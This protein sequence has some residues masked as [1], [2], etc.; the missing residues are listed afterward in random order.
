MG[1][2]GDTV[3]VKRGGLV[4]DPETVANFDFDPGLTE[5]LAPFVEPLYKHYWRIDTE[6]L[7]HIPEE[8]GCLLVAN[9]GGILPFDAAMVKMAVYTKS[10][11]RHAW[12]LIER[13]VQTLPFLNV[14]FR[15][16]GQVLACEENTLYLLRRGEVVLVFPEGVRGIAKP[17]HQRYRLQR[18]GRGGFVRTARLAGVPI[19]PVAVVGAEEIYRLLAKV[20]WPFKYLGIPFLPVTTTFPWLGML[21]AIPKPTRWRIRFLPPFTEH[22]DIPGGVDEDL[23]IQETAEMVRT[24]TQ[25]AIL[26]MLRKRRGLYY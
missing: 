3:P 25:D 20:H 8:S 14:F 22:L 9:H 7:E 10:P 5:R 24:M 13:F 21:G 18:Y 23:R 12:V 4:V 6:G 26:D 17:H 19:I 16:T 1:R 2:P 15:R 11:P